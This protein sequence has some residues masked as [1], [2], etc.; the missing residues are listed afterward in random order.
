[1]GFKSA[2][3]LSIANK[4]RVVMETAMVKLATFGLTKIQQNMAPRRPPGGG[5]TRN[6]ANGTKLINEIKSATATKARSMFVVDRIPRF[7]A[8]SVMTSKF[9]T[10]PMALSTK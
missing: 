8:I 3:Y 6:E 5:N 10:T 4:T 1:M 2:R 9:P 7:L